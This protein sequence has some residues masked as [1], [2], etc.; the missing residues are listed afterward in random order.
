VEAAR[1]PRRS[2]IFH[3]HFGRPL[4]LRRL[5]QKFVAE[6]ARAAIRW[7]MQDEERAARPVCGRKGEVTAALSKLRLGRTEL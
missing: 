4:L 2:I 5:P 7:V 1:A 3:R 6:L